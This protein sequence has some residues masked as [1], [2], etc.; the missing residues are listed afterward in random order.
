ML[1]KLKPNPTELLLVNDS[2]CGPLTSMAGLFARFRAAGDGLFGLTENLAPK[3]HLQ[4]YFLL[5]RG[6]AAVPDLMRFVI[7]MQLTAYKRAI[8]R[9]GEIRL[10]EWMRERGHLVAVPNSYECVERLALRQTRARRRLSLLYPRS[11][12][13]ASFEDWL[14]TLQSLPANPTHAFWYE[15]VEC[16]DFP[17]VKTDVLARNQM[18]LPDIEDWPQLVRLDSTRRIIEAHLQDM[19]KAPEARGGVEGDVLIMRWVS[20]LW[21]LL[22]RVS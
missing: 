22:H 2:V 15:L 17:F 9:R 5:A 21:K 11:A 16:C 13:C 14:R 8:I 18:R 6:H 3:P 7:K 1:T 10:S 4:S 20:G 19:K 12:L